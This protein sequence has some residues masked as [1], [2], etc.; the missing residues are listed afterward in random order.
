MMATVY[1][2]S[3]SG[4]SLLRAKKVP[5]DPTPYLPSPGTLDRAVGALERLGFTIEARGATLS[6][7]GPPELFSRV[8]VTSAA[9]MAIP[10]LED[11]IEGIT[12]AI[13]GVPFSKYR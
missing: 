3:R 10:G 8:C 2:R 7:S 4:R 13:P 6:I 1:L 12:P 9:G 5:A 11:V